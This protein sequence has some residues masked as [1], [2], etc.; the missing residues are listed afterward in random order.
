MLL[1]H[2]TRKCQPCCS[3]AGT[4]ASIQ[5][6]PANRPGSAMPPVNMREEKN[7]PNEGRSFFILSI[8]LPLLRAWL[9]GTGCSSCWCCI[10]AF[11]MRTGSWDDKGQAMWAQPSLTCTAAMTYCCPSCL[12]F[13]Q[14]PWLIDMLNVNPRKKQ[15]RS[16][17]TMAPYWLT[18]TR[19]DCQVLEAF[20]KRHVSCP[21]Q[22]SVDILPRSPIALSYYF[23]ASYIIESKGYWEICGAVME[24]LCA[25]SFC[26]VSVWQTV[27]RI[28]FH[29]Y[30]VVSANMPRFRYLDILLQHPI[31][32]YKL[33]E[34]PESCLPLETFR[35]FAQETFT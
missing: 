11:Y 21:G 15:S 2:R 28:D 14:Y 20:C 3:E 33:I 34:A 13:A 29:I 1:R 17:R 10:V 16:R 35:R 30:Y 31:C 25:F 24:A 18:A 8:G 26:P 6:S 4:E 12:V 19:C 5:A 27:S 9:D 32:I 23:S 22:R 7:D